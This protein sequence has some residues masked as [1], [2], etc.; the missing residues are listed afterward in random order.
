MKEEQEVDGSLGSDRFGCVG[1]EH[2]AR[3]PLFED[4][5]ACALQTLVECIPE[6]GGDVSPEPG[7]QPLVDDEKGVLGRDGAD[8][9]HGEKPDKEAASPAGEHLW[10]LPQ[11]LAGEVILRLVL[12][13][14][15][16]GNQQPDAN[17]L[18]E[19][20]ECGAKDHRDHK[21]RL[22]PNVWP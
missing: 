9:K 18:E 14:C 2:L 6:V 15:D 13:Q 5:E 20:G 17:H 19:G 4:V 21:P 8:D 22:R 16:E 11:I 3:R 10:D 1:A 12:E 7:L